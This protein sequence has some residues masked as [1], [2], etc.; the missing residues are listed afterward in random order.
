MDY[1]EPIGKTGRAPYVNGD[2]DNGIEGDLVSG[3]A[4]EHPMREIIQVIEDAGLEPDAADLTQLSQAVTLIAQQNQTSGLP[5]GTVISS[6]SQTVP[7]GYLLCDGAALDRTVFADLFLA[8]GTF[9]GAGDGVNTFN[10]PDLRGEF[11]R[12]WDNGR[13]VDPARVFGAHQEAIAGGLTSFHTSG[14]HFVNASEADIEPAPGTFSDFF[15]TGTGGS[16]TYSIRFG[17][18]LGPVPRNVA[19]NFYIKF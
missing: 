12:G 6:A 4:V 16:T 17:A 8:I 15:R 11:L 2:P 5:L 18:G 10:I 1:V 14:G 13:G 3:Q 7:T 9:W 19:V